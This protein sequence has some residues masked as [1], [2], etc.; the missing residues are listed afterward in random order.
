MQWTTYSFFKRLFKFIKEFNHT[1]I[2]TTNFDFKVKSDELT[3]KDWT[4]IA[5]FN[6]YAGANLP[7]VSIL[8]E[9]APIDHTDFPKK[10]VWIYDNLTV[11]DFGTVGDVIIVEPVIDT[12]GFQLLRR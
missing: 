10:K 9:D 11:T 7:K 2:E 5:W 1:P 3:D 8:L 4:D 12:K 6:E